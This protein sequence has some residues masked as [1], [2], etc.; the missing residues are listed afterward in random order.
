MSNNVFAQL[1][2]KKV[3]VVSGR[4]HR[5][6]AHMCLKR[7]EGQVAKLIYLSTHVLKLF[8]KWLR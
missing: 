4:R 5:F 6:L 1:V 8:A 3:A 7:C 2:L